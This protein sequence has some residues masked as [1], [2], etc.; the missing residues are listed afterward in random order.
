MASDEE[1]KPEAKLNGVTAQ[2]LQAVS[3]VAAASAM[4]SVLIGVV[5]FFA[6][7]EVQDQFQKFAGIDRLSKV[8][9]TQGV[10]LSSISQA[11]EAN[12]RAINDIQ[13]PERVVEYDALRSRVF[14][15]CNEGEACEYQIRARRTR[16]GQ[17][18]SAPTV[19]A[20][21]VIDS[22]GIVNPVR[23]ADNNTP[24]RID[25]EW[26]TIRSSFEIPLGIAEGIAEFMMTLAYV[27]DGGKIVEQDTLRLPFII[28][29]K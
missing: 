9:Q 4:M 29:E 5:W 8:Q 20:R 28:N 27:C 11:V 10:Q 12:S 22:A 6:R 13:G 17:P 16:F 2:L 14:T 24:R 25:G 1:G 19:V 26:S 21:I 3:L 18:C 23:Q 7:N 15:P